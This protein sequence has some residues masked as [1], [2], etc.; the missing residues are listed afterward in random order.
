MPGAEW[1]AGNR[2]FVCLF[3]QERPGT[4]T[5]ESYVTSYFPLE[6]RVCLNDN[7]FVPC[8]EPHTVERIAVFD[9]DAAVAAGQ[10]PGE[11]ARE[12]DHTVDLSDE[13]WAELDSV[14]RSYLD[15]VS[16]NPAEGLVGLAETYDTI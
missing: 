11:E 16:S 15:A 12:K 2:S 14:C 6:G 3:V 1:D 10:L 8:T 13:Q 5:A 9:V 4:T 7:D